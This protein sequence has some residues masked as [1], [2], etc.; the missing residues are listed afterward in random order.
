MD[1]ELPETKPR[2]LVFVVAYNAERTIEEVLARIPPA[3]A[4]EYHVEVL[5]IDDSSQDRT[6]ER[7]EEVRRAESLP[8]KLHLLYNRVNQVYGGNQK[9]GFHFA[10]E[11]DFDFVALLHGDGQ[12]APECLPE[13][14]KPLAAGE[15]DA[16]FGS[17]MLVPGAARAGG[18]PLYKYVG[19]KILTRAQNTLLRTQLSEFHSGYRVYSID[20]LRRIPF[21]LNTKGFHFD[22]E[23]IIELVLAEQRI[24]ELPI[25]TYYGD[26]ICHV[27]GIKYG[28]D[29]LKATAKARIQDLSLLYDRKFDCRPRD[30]AA[31]H[32]ALKLGYDSPH[33]HVLE[34]VEPGSRVL[35]LGC[36]G[37]K[38]AAEL[39]R[40][41]CVV[42]GVDVA[43]LAPGIELDA[44][45]EHDLDH[46]Q[47]P[48]D[49]AEFDYILL[50]DV[51]EHLRS[52]ELFIERLKQALG[53]RPEVKLILSTGN[54]AFGLTRLL[55]LAGQFNYGKRGILDLTHT[56]LFTFASLRQLL[57]GA[58][59]DVIEA[60]GIPAPFPLALGQRRATALLLR[61]N[62]RL[63]RLRKQLFSYQ[64]FVIAEPRPSLPYLL[65]QARAESE[66]RIEAPQRSM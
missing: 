15:A 38:L 27:N 37:G 19:N 51:L 63:A 39:R 54:V 6:F 64:I 29:V 20:A 33:T 4:N 47:L 24:V 21:D 30:A 28:L 10:I 41:G 61:L 11:R 66:V 12:Y 44:F 55:L 2:L 5:V 52:P 18:M 57:H 26:E 25:P 50:L 23:I 65:E 43:P 1:E 62:R 60:R 35:D 40:R 46:P 14:V 31:T 53:L 56:R 59:F 48:V 36:A 32:Y 7:G 3:L 16:V 8:F 17:R 45:Y 42:V 13:L 9:I 58:G 34:L 49:P 22:T